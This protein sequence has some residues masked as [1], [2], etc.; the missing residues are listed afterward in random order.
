MT[1]IAAETIYGGIKLET[2]ACLFSIEVRMMKQMTTIFC[3]FLLLLAACKGEGSRLPALDM[4]VSASQLT[5]ASVQN[6]TLRLVAVSEADE[7]LIGRP[8]DPLTLADLPG[9]DAVDFG[10]H[11]TYTLSP[12]SRTL[13]L[14]TWPSG[15]HNRGGTLHLLELSTWELTTTEITFDAFVAPLRFGADGRALYWTEPAR[16]DPAHGIP[17][18]YELYRY[19]LDSGQLTAVTSLPPSFIPWEMQRLSS[20]KQLAIYGIPTD[21]NNLVE[22]TPH[23]LLIDLAAGNIAADIQL[24]G[25]KAGQFRVQAAAEDEPPYR[26]VRPGLAWDLERDL[27]YVAHAEEEKVTV[28]DLVAAEI[29]RQTDIWGQQT[30]L[31]RFLSWGVQV[32]EAKVVPGT[33]RQAVLAP[34]GH[35]LY[36][37]GLL[38]EMHPAEDGDGWVYQETPLGLQVIAT[39]KLTEVQR[40]DLPV[41]DLALSPDGRWLLL[42]SAY[43]TTG[44]DGGLERVHHG[45]YLVD[46]TSLAVT[47]HL[48]P[49]REVYFQGFSPDG[50][51]AYVSTAS[52]EWLGDHYGNWRG[53]LH[54]LDLQSGQFVAER[55]FVGGYLNLI[56]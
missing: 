2:S 46:T 19:N 6:A 28:V 35:V 23:V 16:R 39:E 54:V 30:L 18:D 42:R 22:D 40:L 9:Y 43:D 12:D 49:E 10:H 36:T 5:Q 31:D 50:R 1:G 21:T 29:S 55:A 13:A 25:V 27:L 34:G 7:G 48:M 44:A 45:L 37:V 33:D 17:R 32:A 53:T 56:P 8:I 4:G 38:R 52:S 51:H 20:G 47:A 41:T 15:S 11:N 14:I 3:A 24:E 26:M